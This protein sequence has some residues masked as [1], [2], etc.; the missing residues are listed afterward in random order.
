MIVLITGDFGVG[1]DTF[2]DMLDENFGDESVKIK[3]YTTREKRY[4]TEDTHI[5][6]D[7]FKNEGDIVARTK[8]GGNQYWTRRDQFG[9][10]PYDIYVVDDIGIRDVLEADIDEVFVVEIQRPKELID[11]CEL[12]LNR[13]RT[14]FYLYTPDVVIQNDTMSLE[15]LFQLADQLYSYIKKI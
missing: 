2:A 7:K 11:V 6:V 15:S 14:D 8:I 10:K 4:S 1:K 9:T 3:S 12:R 13:E 5:F